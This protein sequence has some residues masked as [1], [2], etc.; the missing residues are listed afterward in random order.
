MATKISAGLATKVSAIMTEFFLIL[1]A[2]CLANNLVTD[3]LLGVSPLLA[4]AQKINIAVDMAIAVT[5]VTTLVAF[6]TCLLDTLFITPLHLENYR[7]LILVMTVVCVCHLSRKIP[8]RFYPRLFDR[9][10]RFYPLL[11]MNCALLGVTLLNGQQ[12][13]G[14][15]GSLFF[16][17]GAGLGFSLILLG[18]TAINLRLAVTDLPTP[19]KGLPLQ[20]VTLGIISL[21]FSGFAGLTP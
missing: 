8:G 19:F 5:G 3:H 11:L 12:E 18:F 20:M 16:G 9:D 2:A 1:L 21:A 10:G 7:L 15:L 6:I 4:A 14:L 13:T 17:A